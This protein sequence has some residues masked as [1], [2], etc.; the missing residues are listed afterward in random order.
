MNQKLLTLIPGIEGEEYVYVSDLTRNLSD[1]RLAFFAAVYNGKRQK[2]ETILITACLG[3]VIVAG[4]HRFILNQIGMGILYL[5]TGGLCL[6]GTIVDV[7]NH[8][9]LTN[10]YNIRMANESMN[11][12]D[13][14]R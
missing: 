1:D 7:I 14:L 2:S 9:K 11:M 5:L 6:I 8:K 10:E 12:I 3:F 13:S 4:V